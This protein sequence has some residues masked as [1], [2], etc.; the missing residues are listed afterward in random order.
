M[1]SWILQLRFWVN[2]AVY[3]S[4]SR[5]RLTSKQADWSWRLKKRRISSLPNSHVRI[6]RKRKKLLACLQSASP[7]SSAR[8]ECVISSDIVKLMSW[9]NSRLTRILAQYLCCVLHLYFMFSMITR[10]SWSATSDNLMYISGMYAA[11]IIRHSLFN[12]SKW[13]G[14]WGGGGGGVERRRESQICCSQKTK[15]QK[16][17]KV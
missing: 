3:G 2:N 5:Q 7:C 10:F 9:R 13:K 14:E 4:G 16:T 6:S 8:A 1:P 11:N 17:K 12:F 15:K